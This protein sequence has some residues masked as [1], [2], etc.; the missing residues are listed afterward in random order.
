MRRFMSERERSLD[1]QRADL[2]RAEEGFVKSRKEAERQASKS[3][4]INSGSSFQR[5]AALQEE[6]DKL[7]VRGAC[8]LTD[9]SIDVGS[10][11]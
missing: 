11:F 4:I 3:K 5:E 6:I 10:G 8:L 2:R 1:K 9:F 7:M